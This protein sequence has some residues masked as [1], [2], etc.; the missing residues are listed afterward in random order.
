MKRLRLLYLDVPFENESGGDK[1]RSRFL[2]QALQERCDVDLVLM[3]QGRENGRAAFTRYKPVAAFPS[4]KP[5]FPR[6]ASTP[7]F[8]RRSHDQLHELVRSGGYDMVFSRFCTGWELC[9]SVSRHWPQLS[10]VV[11][12]DMLSSRLVALSWA[13]NPSFRRRWFLFEKWKLQRFE[14]RLFREPWLFL[15]TNPA[16]LA[17][18]RDH[19]APRVT[20]GEFA[21]LPNTMPRATELQDIQRKPI[22]LFFGSMDSAANTDAYAFLVDEVVPQ[23]ETDLKQQGVEI[24]VVGKNPPASFRDRLARAGTDCVKIIGGVQSIE[25]AIAESLFVFLPLRIA[26]GTRTRILEAAAQARAVVTTAIGA[27]GLSLGDSVLI[28]DTADDLVAHARRLLHNPKEADA[29]GR[30]CQLQ[31]LS[32]YAGNKV[33]EDLVR[34]VES[35]AARKRGGAR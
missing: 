17:Q 3:Q 18:A 6:S 4:L 9:D 21:L 13:A 29:L 26:S 34:V 35:F 2:W 24:H 7:A 1:N 30:L 8:S 27:E 19:V 14:K 20:E 15:F 32:L 10:V 31:A 28:G 23:L 12:V 16:E 5:S 25:Q 33:A 22:V 11:D